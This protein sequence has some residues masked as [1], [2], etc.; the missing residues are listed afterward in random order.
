MTGQS[1][2]GARTWDM[3]QDRT[4]AT[5]TEQPILCHYDI[6]RK[7]NVLDRIVLQV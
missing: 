1:Q 5:Y 6:I 2:T 7:G 3:G 4:M